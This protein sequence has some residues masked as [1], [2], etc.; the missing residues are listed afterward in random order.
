MEIPHTKSSSEGDAHRP[1]LWKCYECRDKTNERCSYCL[2]P[3]CDAHGERVTPWF[4]TRR[5]LVCPPCQARLREIE[6][7]E[8]AL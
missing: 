3:I 6:Q 4:T 2:L 7:E 8:Q 5:V 1:G